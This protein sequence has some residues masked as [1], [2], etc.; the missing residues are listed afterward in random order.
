MHKA[1]LCG[2]L[3]DRGDEAR[4]IGAN[5]ATLPELLRKEWREE[6]QRDVSSYRKSSLVFRA[7]FSFEFFQLPIVTY[8]FLCA[9]TKPPAF[10]HPSGGD[11]GP[12]RRI[13]HSLNALQRKNR[14]A[15]AGGS[16][17]RGSGDSRP[18]EGQL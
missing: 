8:T 6:A 7:R 11:G 18:K 16:P 17:D 15:S 10:D 3:R 12:G 9:K 4:R 2:R 1:C 5:I 14:R 13:W